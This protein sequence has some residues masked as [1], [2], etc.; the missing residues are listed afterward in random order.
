P[1][2]SSLFP[3]TT[4]FRSAELRRPGAMRLDVVHADAE[5][6]RLQRLE[7]R[8]PRAEADHLGRAD[9]GEV[10]GIEEQDDP[11]LAE[12]GERERAQ[13]EI[14]RASCRERGEVAV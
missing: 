2:A 10:G 6:L 8:E 4:L 1:P 9:E 7:L 14:G 13:L 11:L 12:V 3:Y 5:H